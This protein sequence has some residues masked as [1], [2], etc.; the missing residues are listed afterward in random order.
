M[1]CKDKRY[2]LRETKNPLNIKIKI[3]VV[4]CFLLLGHKGGRL[5]DDSSNNPTI[6]VSETDPGLYP[7]PRRVETM[8]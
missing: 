7:N 5:K 8:N 2:G 1:G 4:I 6:R 3:G